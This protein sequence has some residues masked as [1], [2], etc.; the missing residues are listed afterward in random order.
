MH[1]L[2]QVTDLV[3]Y[4]DGQLTGRTKS[5]SLQLFLLRVNL[6]KKRDT[7]GCCLPVP[8]WA[9]PMISQPSSSTGMAFAWIGDA[10]SNPISVTA[11][12]IRSSNCNSS[13]FTVS[14]HFPHSIYNLFS[15]FRKFVPV[16][17][18]LGLRHANTCHRQIFAHNHMKKEDSGWYSES[19]SA[20]FCILTYGFW[21]VNFLFE[22]NPQLRNP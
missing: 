17:E 20:Q 22:C 2:C 3:C 15:G 5:N 16:G 14:I 12:R 11:R 4:L 1:I 10:S 9:W 7:K 13:N 21:N 6:L 8:V 18:H 19:S